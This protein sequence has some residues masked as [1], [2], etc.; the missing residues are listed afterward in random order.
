MTPALLM[1]FETHYTLQFVTQ[2]LPVAGRH[3]LEVGCG[4]GR[5]AAALVADGWRVTAI[6]QNV[7]AV[8]KAQSRGVAAIR[9]DWPDYSTDD[10]YDAVLFVR[11]IHHI[12]DLQ[13]AVDRAAELLR[14]DGRVI[15]DDFAVEAMDEATAEW[16]RRY[17]RNLPR[18]QSESAGHGLV[19]ALSSDGP[20]LH[21]W[22]HHHEHHGVIHTAGD[23]AAALRKR[24]RNVSEASVPYLFRYLSESGD[25]ADALVSACFE[26]ECG[27]IEDGLIRPIGRRFL[28]LFK[29]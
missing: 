20:A 12:V 6:D 13:G 29:Q 28:G 25:G 2:T 17:V 4:D 19:A 15:V 10:R 7:E 27:A 16:F 26:H 8:R 3:V 9:S 14:P 23:I 24:F 22:R 18:F 11:S 5:L 21:I 1:N